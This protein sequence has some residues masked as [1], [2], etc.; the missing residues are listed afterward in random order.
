VIKTVFTALISAVIGGLVT[1]LFIYTGISGLPEG[2]KGDV[3]VREASPSGGNTKTGGDG[4]NNIEEIYDRYGP[5]VVSLDIA[6]EG[7]SP[8]GGSGFV[9]DKNGHIVT[10]QHVVEKAENISVQFPGGP[11]KEAKVIGEDPSTDLAL[12]KVD[13]P[14]EVLKPLTLGDSGNMEV[15]DRVVAIG[16]PLNV[17]ISVSS[18]IISGLDRSIKAPN[19]YTIDGALQ[20]DAA[21]NPGSSG[22]PLL[23]KQGNVIGV[24]SQIASSTGSFQGV[25]FA[26]P[27]NTVKNV[28]KQLASGGDV[29]HAYL[30]VK[31]LPVGIEEL[32]AYSGS[33]PG[34]FSGEHEI[35]E[36]GAI[37]SEAVRGGP[38]GSAGIEGGEER[39]IEGVPVPVPKGDVITKVE[40]KK[41]SGPEDVISEVNSRKPGDRM[42][43]TVVSPGGDP[44]KV[45]VR[46][47]SQPQ[48]GS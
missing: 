44:Q 7:S 3:V 43:L 37:V 22:G 5:G 38:A 1:A 29:E 33:S 18:G 21:V 45:T 31:M 13:A 40:G 46:L 14:K 2:S 24:T 34:Q 17:G 27:S 10:N 23:D 12:L 36:N 26:V 47:G 4:N 28:V 9:L 8:A 39:R 30:G 41:V 11:R 35:P 20:T 42:G 48:N 16:N 25:G 32:A 15:G 19:N 6:A